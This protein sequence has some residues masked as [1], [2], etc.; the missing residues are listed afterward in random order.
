MYSRL[1]THTCVYVRTC[2]G[3]WHVLAEGC[4]DFSQHMINTPKHQT[5]RQT[6][7]HTGIQTDRK[8]YRQTD[9]QRVE[10]SII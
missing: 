7:R 1:C 6:D 4:M 10:L 5:D 2:M 3:T 8:T 9:R